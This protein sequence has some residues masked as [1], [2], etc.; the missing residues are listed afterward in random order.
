MFLKR[1]EVPKNKELIYVSDFIN[2]NIKQFIIYYF[3]LFL[4]KYVF[5]IILFLYQWSHQWMVGYV[6]VRHN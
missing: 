5:Y 1:E 4:K 2:E 6:D 3:I